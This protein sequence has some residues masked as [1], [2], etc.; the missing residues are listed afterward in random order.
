MPIYEYACRSCAR[1]FEALVLK[2][3]VPACPECESRDLER[4]LSPPVVRS[5]STRQQV[6]SYVKQRDAG[7]AAEKAHAQQQYER[8][9]ND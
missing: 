2:N 9:H 5:E 1:Q 3:T 4:L 6:S 8:S 7:Q